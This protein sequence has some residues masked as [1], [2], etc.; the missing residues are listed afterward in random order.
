[1]LCGCHRQAVGVGV[2]LGGLSLRRK[3]MSV[4]WVSQAGCRG[5]GR[6]GGAVSA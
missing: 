6:V 1:M 5:G 2:G 4:V 3:G